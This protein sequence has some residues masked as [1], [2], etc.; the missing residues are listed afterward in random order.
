MISV[1]RKVV[2]AILKL[3]N[4][5]HDEMTTDSTSSSILLIRNIHEVINSASVNASSE[6]VSEAINRLIDKGYLR[7][8]QRW[9][10]GFSFSM[11]SLMKHRH[12]F[13][14]DGF[15]K[16]F[17]AGFVAG[18]FSGIIVTVLGELL[19]AYLRAKLGI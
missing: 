4:N 9:Y 5:Y 1:D 12:A 8:V 6:D 14:W 17:W 11:T 2:S 10:G 18:I 7:V 19:L 15:T 13:W 3:T 16:R